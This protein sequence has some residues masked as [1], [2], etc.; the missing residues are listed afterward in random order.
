MALGKSAEIIYD[1]FKTDYFEK[2]KKKRDYLEEKIEKLGNVLINGK[3]APRVP[4]TINVSFKDIEAQALKNALNYEGIAVSS[5]SACSSE[6][7]AISHVLEAMGV[8]RKT[9]L[10]TIRISIGK[11]TTD[12]DIE[13]SIEKI[14]YWVKKL[15]SFLPDD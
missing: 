11:Y 10:G 3:E 14:E 2:L 15:R 7:E 4:N 6:K 8:D 5:G 9:A 1:D 13:Y 12:E